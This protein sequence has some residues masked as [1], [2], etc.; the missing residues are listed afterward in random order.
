MPFDDLMFESEKQKATAY[1]TK[2]KSITV[3]KVQD[4]YRRQRMSEELHNKVE[5]AAKQAEKLMMASLKSKSVANSKKRNDKL[6]VLGDLEYRTNNNNEKQLA[7]IQKEM[8]ERE[9]KHKEKEQ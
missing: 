4:E 7:R 5:K 6:K 8:S 2:I 3:A 1:H 9:Q